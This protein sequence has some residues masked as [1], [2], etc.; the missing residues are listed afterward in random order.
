[1]WGRVRRGNSATCSALHW[2]SV[3]SSTVWRQIG[4]FWCWLPV[5]GG[6]A[7][8]CMFWDPV[9]LSK[10]LSCKAGS[11]SCCLNPHRFFQSE[12]LRLYFPA[13]EPWVVW[14]VSLPNCSSWFI[15]TQRW[16]LPLCQPPP[17]SPGSSSCHLSTSP[18][19]PSC[20]SLPLLLIWMNVSSLT[21]WLSDFPYSSI[22]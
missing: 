4:P 18:L 12:V 13:L 15:C 5:L 8:L 14:S 7:I 9:G 21:P 6:W 22:C 19:H 17:C 10:E 11:F 20:L 1:M 16:D 3:T 2:L